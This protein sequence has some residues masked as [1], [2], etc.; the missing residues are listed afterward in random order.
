MGRAVDYEAAWEE[1]QEFIL[2]RDGW[3]TRTLVTEMAT[4]RVKHTLPEAA[5]SA[6]GGMTDRARD[7]PR[8]NE[9]PQEDRDVNADH[10]EP[11]RLRRA[12]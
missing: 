1:L 11:V 4:L 10:A 9:D 6:P 7:V 8:G 2:R 12:G 3:G 5:P